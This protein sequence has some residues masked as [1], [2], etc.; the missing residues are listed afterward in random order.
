MVVGYTI[1]SQRVSSQTPVQRQ[2]PTIPSIHSTI[3]SHNSGASS[4]P[5]IEPK[6]QIAHQAS[7][8][9]PPPPSLA[10]GPPP[11]PLPPPAIR[12]P[13]PS[14]PPPGRPSP[15][16]EVVSRLHDAFHNAKLGNLLRS[17][18]DAGVYI[19]SFDEWEDPVR[20]WLPCPQ[21]CDHDDYNGACHACSWKGD[22]ISASVIHSQLGERRDR[23]DGGIPLVSTEGGLIL[24]PASVTILCVFGADGATLNSNC[25]PSGQSAGCVPG[26]GNPPDWCDVDQPL[27]MNNCRC[28]FHN[29][30]GRP[31][32]YQPEHLGYVMEQHKLHG[33]EWKSPQF[34][35]GYNE[36]VLDGTD[37]PAPQ[38]VLGF[39]IVE[40]GTPQQEAKTREVHRKFLEEYDTRSEADTP[41]LVLR[42]QNWA[43]PFE[44]IGAQGT[45]SADSHAIREQ[46]HTHGASPS[47]PLQ[48]PSA[49]DFQ[50]LQS[51]CR[52]RIAY[53]N[54]CIP[55]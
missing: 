47:V 32:P 54:S 48:P 40:G 27:L 3:A 44:L 33:I 35:S 7:S 20:R 28:S 41:L 16:L 2:E 52:G 10:P 25:Q 29:C 53:D 26:C 21:T 55:D 18:S 8:P 14:P 19:H 23:R 6:P 9:P 1:Y 39:Y 30:N 17:Q 51:K 22:R 36:V 38:V 37:W 45:K 49:P 12:S 46:T 11:L 13:P 50:T 42:P 31:R 4:A 24:D 15:G 34:H 5:V 43:V